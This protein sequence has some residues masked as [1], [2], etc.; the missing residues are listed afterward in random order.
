MIPVQRNKS[1]L[2]I[3][4][5]VLLFILLSGRL[6][7]SFGSAR[8]WNSRASNTSTILPG[9]EPKHNRPLC[10]CSGLGHHRRLLGGWVVRITRSISE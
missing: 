3:A 5:L 1:Q 6:N 2:E 10:E 4:V 9:F 7:A 8:R